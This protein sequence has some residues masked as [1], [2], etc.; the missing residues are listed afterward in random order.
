M[1]LSL[2]DHLFEAPPISQ[3][4]T[5]EFGD[6]IRLLGYDVDTSRA[7]SGGEIQLVL[8]WQA[9]TTPT[10]HY[11][12][13]THVIGADGQIYGQFDS[14]PSGEAWLTGTW[15]PGEV[16]IDQRTIPLRQELAAGTYEMLV[17]LYTA[18]DSQ[19]L[20]VTMEGQPQAGDQLVLTAVSIR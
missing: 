15:L 18:A 9:I 7:K 8:Y 14:P 11:T 10:D 16:V 20:P 2:R 19:R 3:P 12:V 13:F 17:G 1:T 5:A 4:L 6:A